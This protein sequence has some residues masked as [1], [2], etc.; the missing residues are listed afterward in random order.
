MMSIEDSPLPD[1]EWTA[2]R[3]T[4]GDGLLARLCRVSEVSLRRYA[5]RARPTPDVV[6]QRLHI[7]ALIV[8]DLRGAYN[9]YGVRRWFQ[10]RTW[11]APAWTC[12]QW[13]GCSPF[14]QPTGS[15]WLVS[16]R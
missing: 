16:L 1:Q 8:A 3:N 11:H 4:L 13:R 10:R 12:P 15:C 9:D 7:L 5:A 14:R 6:A 2:L